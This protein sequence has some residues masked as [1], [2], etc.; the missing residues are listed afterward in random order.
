M[1]GNLVLR[2]SIWWMF[3]C[4]RP[5]KNQFLDLYS[6]DR[7]H[8][9]SGCV[10]WLH[11][12]RDATSLHHGLCLRHHPQVQ[13]D[14]GGQDPR[15]GEQLPD[16]RVS[17]P[18]TNVQQILTKGPDWVLGVRGWSG[19]SLNWLANNFTGKI[20]TS[21]YCRRFFVC[22]LYCIGQL[23]GRN[24]KGLRT[25]NFPGGVKFYSKSL[26]IIKRNF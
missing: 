6:I 26:A 23:Q 5:G 3:Q 25:R 11:V 14:R 4:I 9:W 18:S 22:V 16:C 10:G 24:V 19:N 2:I 15:Q 21:N 8:L 13:A 12:H 1:G 7:S 17:V 20:K